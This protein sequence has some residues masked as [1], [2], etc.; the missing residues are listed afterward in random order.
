MHSFKFEITM[1]NDPEKHAGA[2]VG[3]SMRGREHEALADPAT[4]RH[5]HTSCYSTARL[6]TRP[7]TRTIRL[8]SRA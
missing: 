1:D 6:Y 4:L 5:S 3:S 2:S 7:I 8:N